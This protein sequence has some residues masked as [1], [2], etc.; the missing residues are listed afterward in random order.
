M[1]AEVFDAVVISEEVRMR[2]PDVEIFKLAVRRVDLDPGECV[3]IDDTAANLVGALELGITTI[4]HTDP[5]AT[6]DRLQELLG[7]DLQAIR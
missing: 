4:H 1:L 5:Q 3:F 6:L 7:V 2:K